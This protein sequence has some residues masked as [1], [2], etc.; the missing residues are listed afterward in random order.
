MSR[1]LAVRVSGAR[2]DQAL[3]LRHTDAPNPNQI[4]MSKGQIAS[5]SGSAKIHARTKG[6][7][8]MAIRVLVVDDNRVWRIVLRRWF[9]P[10]SPGE[11]ASKP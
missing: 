7:G 10:F 1:G 9:E 5:A 2:D 4:A 6:G 11:S 8:A 3:A